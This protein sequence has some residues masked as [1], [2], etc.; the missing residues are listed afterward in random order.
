MKAV[1]LPPHHQ[2]PCRPEDGVR[3]EN[4]AK[5]RDEAV[6]CDCDLTSVREKRSHEETPESHQTA[7]AAAAAAAA[8]SAWCPGSSLRG[9]RAETQRAA[10]RRQRLLQPTDAPLQRGVSQN[11]RRQ[12][13]SHSCCLYAVRSTGRSAFI[14]PFC[15]D[16][17]PPLDPPTRRDTMTAPRR[18]APRALRTGSSFCGVC[19]VPPVV[20]N[21][22]GGY[23]DVLPVLIFP[24]Y[25]LKERDSGT[26]QRPVFPQWIPPSS[27]SL[28]RNRLSIQPLP[29]PLSPGCRDRQRRPHVQKRNPAKQSTSGRRVAARR[30]EMLSLWA[31]RESLFRFILLI[32]R[33]IIQTDSH[34]APC[35]GCQVVW[36]PP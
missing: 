20:V 19:A 4:A 1:E 12:R 14:S 35:V 3:W 9:Y 34:T 15:K 23:C 27:V 25:H 22:S 30:G 28:P 6:E 18:A 17:P 36:N 31:D 16:A 2:T 29:T 8:T 32:S 26:T 10:V 13:V 21:N 11:I 7:A 33:W 5:R 24:S